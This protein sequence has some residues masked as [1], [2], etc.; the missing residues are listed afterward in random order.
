MTFGKRESDVQYILFLCIAP[1]GNI[2]SSINIQRVNLEIPTETHEDAQR[3]CSKFV[4]D[5]SKNLSVSTVL[6][7]LPS[8][9]FNENPLEFSEYF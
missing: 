6:V 2:F 3:K 9:K 5:F 4:L 1:A 8:I 7:K